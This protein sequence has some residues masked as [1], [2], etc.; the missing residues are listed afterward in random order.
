MHLLPDDHEWQSF[1]EHPKT[2]RDLLPVLIALNNVPS[3][4]RKAARLSGLAR[5]QL[6]SETCGVKR[7]EAI[8]MMG[9]AYAAYNVLVAHDLIRA[10]EAA[11]AHK[12]DE[13]RAEAEQSRKDAVAEL[14]ASM[15]R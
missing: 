4:M 6:T 3:A 11:L 12:L 14:I 13:T 2:L 5:R 10:A 9:I 15:D 7:L 1:A 8:Q